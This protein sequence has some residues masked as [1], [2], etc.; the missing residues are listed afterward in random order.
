MENI[1][2]NAVVIKLGGSLYNSRDTVITDIVRLQKENHNLIIVHGGA[3]L[4]TQWLKRQGCE[5]VFHEGERITDELSLDNV[6]AVL[7][8]LVN[9]EVV[10]TILNAGGR[11]VG[12]SG[13]D[14]GLIRG[15]I[16]SKD[17]GYV[18][19]VV[20]VDPSPLK[21][22]L[23]A[24][25]MPVVAPVSLNAFEK[26]PGQRALLN[27]N[28][29]TVAGAIAESLK[30]EK[31]IF[32]TDVR[33]IKDENGQYLSSL[34]PNGIEELLGS[35]VANGGM[36]PKLKACSV[37]VSNGTTRCSIIDGN[38]KHNLYREIT[39][40]SAGTLISPSEGAS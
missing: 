8:G 39:Q 36:I 20:E 2:D 35:G 31:L 7:G 24:G 15:R 34:D 37:A 25:Y 16:R 19:S 6:A 13:V 38:V 9:K 14:G 1:L 30:V 10:A 32:L 5:T 26:K 18:G 4:V 11:A 40:G 17:T 28:G 27:I 23:A 21:T 22:L 33:G 3:S 29:D 12:I